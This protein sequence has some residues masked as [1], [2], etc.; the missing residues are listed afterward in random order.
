MANGHFR[1]KGHVF[2]ATKRSTLARRFR[3]KGIVTRMRCLLIHGSIFIARAAVVIC[4]RHETRM[5]VKCPR[6]CGAFPRS[7]TP[8]AYGGDSAGPFFC[9]R[10]SNVAIFC[11]C[12]ARQ[13]AQQ[14]RESSV[15]TRRSISVRD[16]YFCPNGIMVSYTRFC[17]VFQGCYLS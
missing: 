10:L 16:G 13:F 15:N 11:V 7:V 2:K 4:L 6:P 14:V 9:N 12:H 5:R 1:L 8:P 3:V 17:L